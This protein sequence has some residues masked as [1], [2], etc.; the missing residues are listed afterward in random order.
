MKHLLKWKY[1]KRFQL[2]EQINQSR[3]P[4]LL[5]TVFFVLCWLLAIP[6]SYAQ[7]TGNGSANAIG[8]TQDKV[9]DCTVKEITFTLVGGDG[10]YAEVTGTGGA[11]ANGGQ[12]ATTTATFAVGN[13]S[14]EIPIGSTIRFVEGAR[15]ESGSSDAVLS[16]GVDYGGGGGG[17]AVLYQAPSS[18][19][20][21]LLAVAGGGGGA[22]VGTGIGIKD[23]QHGEGGREAAGNGNGGGGNI[24]FGGGGGG[25]YSKGD[26]VSCVDININFTSVGGGG[27][28]GNGVG[29]GGNSEGCYSLTWR[30]GGA[31][32]GGGG[33][34]SGV[35][36]GGGGY[37][38]G[39]AG[40]AKQNGSG[41]GSY[42]NSIATSSSKSAG[43]SDANPDHGSITYTVVLRNN[44]T[45][46]CKNAT[47]ELDV[48]GMASIDVDD[49]ENGSSGDGV[50]IVSSSLDIMDFTC[51]DVG[52]N[53]VTLTVTD[54]CGNT[55]TCTSTV[56]VEDNVNPVALCKDITIQLDP[57]GNASI[58][59]ADIDNGSNDACGID[60]LIASKTA[61]TCADVGDNTVTLTVKDKNGNSATCTSTVTVEDNV[62][63]VALCKDTTI[64]LDAFGKASIVATDID[65]GST[66]ACGITSY[67]ASKTDF[68]CAN[69]GNNAVTL[70]VTDVNNNSSTCTANVL[71]EDN[72]RPSV[73]TRNVT[74]V[75][76]KQ[77]EANVTPDMINNGSTDNCTIVSMWLEGLTEY[78][79][80]S[81]GEHEVVLKAEDQSGNIGSWN[82]FVTVKFY[83][84]DFTNIHGVANGDTIHR[85]DCQVP[86][87]ISR[88]DIDYKTIIQHGTLTTNV[89]KEELP[90]NAPWGM[91]AVWRYEYVVKD[92]CYHTYKFNY[93]L[94]L[95]DLA[96][97][98]YQCFPHDTTVATSADVPPV[99]MKVKI[100][101][102][103][104]YVVW[105]TVMTMPVLDIQNGDT[106]GFTRR[107]MARDPSGH[108]SFKDQM[109]WLGSG[110]RKQYSMITGRIADEDHIA[111]A[112]FAG[113][114]GT[115]GLPV[116]LYRLDEGTGT[117]TWVRSW[118][119]GDWMGAQGTY[120]FVPEHPGTYQV[121]I[122]SAICLVDTLKFNKWLWS[123]TLEVAAGESLDQGWIIT[124]D[125]I[126][127]ESIIVNDAEV[128]ES[129]VELNDVIQKQMQ[130]EAEWHV[131]PNP[132]SSY[133]RLEIN[134]DHILAYQIF[135]ALGRPLNRGV[136]QQGQTIDVRGLNAG[137]Y[138]LQL[139]DQKEVLG[140]KRVLLME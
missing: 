38:G 99:D 123:D 47:V 15:G 90:E 57:T 66:D 106:L 43:G 115:N 126:E 85:V 67:F 102:V 77:G 120:Y 86:W 114:A 54:E 23:R 59:G 72:I 119:T 17:S 71:V 138:Y 64:Q 26:G 96:P 88:Y 16:V 36:G 70:T 10:G 124:H 89:Y 134:S 104:Q 135:D 95:Y 105:D 53:T 46:M 48:N 6:V 45:A 91:Y 128:S 27:A 29:A 51:A 2:N 60:S 80:G 98:V 3:S 81:T 50:N 34:G 19:T 5:E 24:A 55:G 7:I 75:L 131:Y 140:T 12:G 76:D 92:A 108:E 116:S 97:P 63:P 13:G 65:N 1:L 84:P 49:I 110:D 112:R 25:K 31:G 61:F 30:N 82:A 139:R 20:W 44:P 136:Y 22:Y 133:L 8:T 32:Y 117:R 73:N 14:G 69:L 137:V 118:T 113:E 62:P 93:Y 21:N 58:T 122:D 68:T 39:A 111:N 52:P 9:L 35:G 121:K 56:T 11:K 100:I 103:C 87:N 132:A 125:C 83:E 107:W 79:C 41:G 74:V 28:G 33:A 40:P 37:T 127:T 18:S 42:V 78:D 129:L 101:D 109:I 130:P 4:S 94:A